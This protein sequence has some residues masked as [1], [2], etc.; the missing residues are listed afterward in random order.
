LHFSLHGAHQLENLATSLTAVECLV[1]SGGS[2]W[3]SITPTTIANG[4]QEVRWPGRLSWHDYK[5]LHLLVDGAHNEGS[6]TA[7]R[8][9]LDS[10]PTLANSP[11]TFVV[12][13]SHSPPKTARSVLEPL[14]RPGD[15]IALTG[16]SPVVGMPWVVPVSVEELSSVSQ[17]IVGIDGT[18]AS[19][20]GAEGRPLDYLRQALE[21]AK[22][23]K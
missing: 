13:L 22:Q 15:S 3:K 12:S 20:C 19:F 18:V 4:I 23:S 9:Y 14:L 21:W 2:S 8:Q 1:E 6:A 10:L 16:F 17:E 7:L 11:R 5:G